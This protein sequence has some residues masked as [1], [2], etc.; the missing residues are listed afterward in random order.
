MIKHTTKKE[1]DFVQIPNSIFASNGISLKAK[2]LL[3]LMLSLPDSWNFSIEGIASR[4]KES[5]QSIATAVKELEDAGY[6]K[7]SMVRDEKGKI[8]KMEYEIF[9]KPVTLTET[10]VQYD[11][12]PD[13]DEVENPSVENPMMESQLMDTPH[14]GNA[15]VNNNIIYKTRNSNITSINNP[16]NPIKSGNKVSIRLVELD[17]CRQNIKENIEYDILVEEDPV[18]KGMIDEIV[19]IMTEIICSNRTEI[20]IS[21]NTYQT[22]YVKR[23]F[24]SINRE[25]IEY[26]ISCISKNTTKIGNIKQYLIST[27]FNAPN[28]IDSYYTTLVKHNMYG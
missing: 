28:T 10:E 26:I 9:E 17:M 23:K 4:C 25:H 5:R 24:L 13:L 8:Q 22:E 20:I 21:G 15:R 11:Q 18:H 6:I 27:I 1:K 2:G 7:R 16:S 19:E 12:E 3:S 14:T